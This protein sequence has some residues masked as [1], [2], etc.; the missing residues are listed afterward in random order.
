[1]AGR[2]TLLQ[3]RVARQTQ[4][5][6]PGRHHASPRGCELN[7]QPVAMWITLNAFSHRPTVSTG[8]Y[9]SLA[10][11]PIIPGKRRVG[12]ERQS[13]QHLRRWASESTSERLLPGQQV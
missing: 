3:R 12:R 10:G 8:H 6:G 2:T 1:M 4:K 11:T 7:D 13:D 9:Y 5:G